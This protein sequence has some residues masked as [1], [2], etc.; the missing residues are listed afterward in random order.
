MVRV[1]QGKSWLNATIYRMNALRGDVVLVSS[2]AR[3]LRTLFIEQLVRR[4]KMRVW[5]NLAVRD[6]LRG[7]WEIIVP[8]R[9][10]SSHPHQFQK[11]WCRPI[12][13]AGGFKLRVVWVRL[14]PP[15]PAFNFKC[16]S[17]EIGET[18][19]T[20]NSAR[21]YIVGPNPT[22][23]TNFNKWECSPIGSRRHVQGV[24]SV[25]SSPSIPTKDDF[26]Q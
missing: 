3:T 26:N 20:Q 1:Q 18:H 19:G 21:R 7:C 13:R 12:G 11:S 16:R 15:G 14:P 17:G 10:K 4:L 9:F 6:S 5:R 25:G 8:W 22:C 23:G 2:P 24:F